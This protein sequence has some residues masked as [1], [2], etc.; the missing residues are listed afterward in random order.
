MITVSGVTICNTWLFADIR[1]EWECWTEYY[2]FIKTKI[3]PNCN[4]R[5]Y[6]SLRGC[7][8][9]DLAPEGDPSKLYPHLMHKNKE[10]L[11]AYRRSNR[12]VKE[13]LEPRRKT[14]RK[15]F[16]EA[17]KKTRQKRNKP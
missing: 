1:G 11:E 10:Y 15:I 12:Y 14:E 4:H 16:Q 13:I 17:V 6:D 9:L 5:I 3:C 2:E 7:D 8:G